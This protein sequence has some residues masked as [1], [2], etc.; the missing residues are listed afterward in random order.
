MTKQVEFLFDFG[1]PYT[2]LG[3]HELG[4]IARN[5]G[6]SITWTPMLLGGVFQATG[7][8]S[9]AEIAAKGE[10]LQT[11]LKRWAK[12][13][14]APFEPNPYFPINTLTLM[15][16]AVGYQMRGQRFLDYVDLIFR[17]MW[18]DQKNLGDPQT[19]SEVLATA[20]FDPADFKAMVADPGIKEQ[21]KKNTEEAIRRGVFGAPSFF[22]GDA[23]FW[24]QDRLLFVEEALTTS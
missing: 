17:A 1:S 4:R 20:H 6:A 8:H 2:Y 24:G 19:L 22:V 23:L 13:F 5:A 15:R 18:A 11:D 14:D 10:W 21:L 12:R 3:Y 9:P 16:G 7:N